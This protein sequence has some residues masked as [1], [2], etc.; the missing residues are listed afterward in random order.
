MTA[1]EKTTYRT[2]VRS[3][4]HTQLARYPS[5]PQLRRALSDLANESG[6]DER[7]PVKTLDGFLEAVRDMTLTAPYGD[8]CRQC[9]DACTEHPRRPDGGPCLCG[10]QPNFAHRMEREGDSL[11]G[12]YRCP[13]GH[14]WTC[15][16]HVDS[17]YLEIG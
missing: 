10:Y 1:A 15:S 8:N 5:Y 12:E 9:M 16:W 6:R 14:K 11:H 4:D 2:A 7:C 13:A 3:F 17:A